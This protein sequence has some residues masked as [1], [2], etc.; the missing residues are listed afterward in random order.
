MKQAQQKSPFAK[1]RRTPIDQVFME[2]VDPVSFKKH[3]GSLDIGKIIDAVWTHALDEAEKS[4]E[5]M[6]V[7]DGGEAVQ[8]NSLM[9]FWRNS[10]ATYAYPVEL[11][12][13]IEDYLERRGI[14]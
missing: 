2:T 6:L 12:K 4:M 5:R 9:A 3:D 10:H 13:K 11:A 8:M 14:R 1:L 7:L